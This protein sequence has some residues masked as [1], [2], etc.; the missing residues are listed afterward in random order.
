MVPRAPGGQDTLAFWSVNE[1]MGRT[2]ARIATN[3]VIAGVHFPVDNV[4]GRLLG[5]VLGEY[6]VYRCGHQWT[7]IGENGPYSLKVWNAGVFNGAAF[8]PEADF[9]P[10]TQPFYDPE[11]CKKDGYYWYGSPYLDPDTGEGELPV[12]PPRSLLQTLFA[13]ARH[14]VAFLQ[15]SFDARR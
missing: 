10:G 9:D 14:E 15:L 6:F 3:R 2:A 4:A 8:P 7:E 11:W 13:K 5:T 12:A 1:Q